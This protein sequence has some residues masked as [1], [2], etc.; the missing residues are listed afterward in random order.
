MAKELGLVDVLGGLD[1]ALKIAIEKAD[2]EGYT[3]ISYPKKDSFLDA[4]MN[5]KPDNYIK[6]HL[7]KGTIGEVY[8]QFGALEN[9]DKCDRIQARLPFELNIE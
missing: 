6:A 5:T 8:Q 7:L 4:L 9:F 3:V 2:V 1:T